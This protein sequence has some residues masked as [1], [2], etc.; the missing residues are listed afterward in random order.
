M[1]RGRWSAWS[2]VRAGAGQLAGN[3]PLRRVIAVWGLW[4]TGEWAVVVVLTIA[5][6][7]QGGTAA[8]AVLAILRTLPPGLA[9]P[10]LGLLADRLRRALVVA[11]VFAAWAVLVAAAALA[12][13]ARSLGWLYVVVC[14]AGIAST[15]LRPGINGLIPQ[16]VRRA[17]EL[18]AANSLYCLVEAGGSLIGPLVAGA[19]VAGA[20]PD[21]ALVCIAVPFAAGAVLAASISSDFQP[22]RERSASWRRA[23]LEPVT[24]FVA[25]TRGRAMRALFALFMAQTFTRGLLN[26]FFVLI[27]VKVLGQRV[28]AT[29]LLVAALGAGGVLGSVFTLAWSGR[30]SARMILI[31]MMLWGVPLLLIAALPDAPV[32]WLALALIGVGN[33]IGDV[34]GYTLMQRLLPDHLLGR[35]FGAFWGGVAL[36][37]SL[38]ALVAP[39]LVAGLGMRAALG[40]AGAF[41]PL[42]LVLAGPAIR[43]VGQQLSADPDRVAALHSCA[44][45]APLTQLA[46]DQLARDARP[47]DVA[48]G[49]LIIEQGTTGDDFYVVVDGRLSAAVDDRPVR[50]MS[51][52]DCFGEIAALHRVARTASVRADTDSRLLQLHGPT[53]ARAVTSHRPAASAAADLSGE[54]LRITA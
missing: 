40:A 33:A 29:S 46:L 44:V 49:T 35:A 37:Q 3:A 11:A 2:A 13:H 41:L 53:F 6:F 31:G 26:V 7:G 27:A 36:A 8:V 23:L 30:R 34:F 43:T 32:A 39:M 5:A 20:A 48:A 51:P 4:I 17:E 54:R 52:G 25:L 45:L 22:V 9:G 42:V 24:G 16:V 28:D 19:L 12:L 21:L 47:M 10:L 15:L 50:V 38:G 1:R 14:A 18:A